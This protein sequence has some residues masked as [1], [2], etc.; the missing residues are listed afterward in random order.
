MNQNNN[1][2]CVYAA[3]LLSVVVWGASFAAAKVALAQAS[4]LTIVFMR[5]ALALVMLALLAAVC[6]E[7][8][9]PTKKQAAVLAFM[10]F[11]GF[12][13]HLGI[14]TIA[15]ETSGS[16]TANWQMAAAPAMVA[17]LAAVFLKEKLSLSGV[18]GIIAA[19]AGVMVVLGLGTKGATGLSAYHIGDFL[20]SVSVLNWAA[21]MVI[22]R[23]LFKGGSYPPIFTIFWE[24][25]FACLMCLPTMFALGVDITAAASFT[26]DTWLSLAVLGFLCSALAYVCWYYAAERIPVAR[27]MVFQFFQPLVG[28][29]VGYVVV[30]ERFTPWLFVGGAM[31]ISGVWSVN[32]GK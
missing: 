5:F 22:T 3:A 4:P 16:A 20:I 25:F 10:G 15:M 9:L 27:L 14:Q 8:R 23:W 32:R 2:L 31:I 24:I 11:M 26:P 6:G 13:F 21:F 12:Y 19:F 1:R 18:C 29:L 7:L 17:V 30:G 28:A